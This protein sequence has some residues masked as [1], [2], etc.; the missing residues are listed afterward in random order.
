MSNSARPTPQFR[1][2]SLPLFQS[3]AVQG[4]QLDGHWVEAFPPRVGSAKFPNII[5]FGRGTSERKSDI[6]MFVNP[7]ADSPNT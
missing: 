3:Q 1:P 6:D 5:A 2:A 4:V 7:Y